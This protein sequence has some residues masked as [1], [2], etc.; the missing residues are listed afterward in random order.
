MKLIRVPYGKK[1]TPIELREYKINGFGAVGTIKEFKEVF[2]NE[3][4]EIIDEV[5]K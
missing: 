5:N 1:D 3:T 2:P 4:F